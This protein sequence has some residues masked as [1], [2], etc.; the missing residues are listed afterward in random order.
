[1][2]AARDTWQAHYAR[3]SGHRYWPTEALVRFLSDKTFGF[4]VEAGCGN[5]ANLWLL[6]EHARCVY[7]VD[8]CSAAIAAARDYARKRNVADRIV[9]SVDSIFELPVSDGE[10]DLVVDVMTG[11]H[12]PWDENPR[13]FVEYRRVLKTGGRFFRYGLSPGTTVTGSKLVSTS[14]YDEVRAFPGV[15]PVVLPTAAQLSASLR[16]SGF[17]V[18]ATEYVTR[19][20]GDGT[21]AAYSATEAIAT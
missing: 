20:Y 12:V 18:A 19:E 4:A 7:G 14:T 16:E 10:A 2:D 3:R 5:G 8:S 6:V 15:G 11:Q 13:L 21:L 17:E 1:M 9:F